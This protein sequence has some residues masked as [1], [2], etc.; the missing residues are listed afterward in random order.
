MFK[1]GGLLVWVCAFL[2]TGPAVA[3][4]AY[5]RF[6]AAIHIHTD[7]S[8]GDESIEQ[9]ATQAVRHGV[10][11]LIVTDDD[12]LRVEYGL[13]FL[14]DLTAVG[15]TVNA[16]FT[17]GTLEEY[18]N[19]I[20]RVNAQYPDVLLIDGIESAPFY[21]WDID[22]TK[23][24]LAFCG[25]NRHTIAVGLDDAVAYAE[26]PVIGGEGNR[27]WHWSSLLLLWPLCGLAYAW[28]WGRAH[29]RW[30]RRGVLVISV[31][32]LVENFPFTV[33][34][35]DAYNG[36]LGPAP[37]Q[38]YIDYVN[39]HNG[40]AFWPHPEAG[41]SIKPL[42]V[43]GGL[44][45]VVS[46][47]PNHGD[48]LVNTYDY[49]GFAALYADAITVTEPGR[50]WDQALGEYVAGQR[51]MPVWGTGEIDYHEDVEGNRIDD[52]LTVFLAR[53]LSRNAVI[54]ALQKGR[55]YAV[56]G[57]D[58]RLVL[59]RFV[60][61]TSQGSAL[62]G[63]TVTSAGEAVVRVRIAHLNQERVPLHV[64]LIKAGEVVAD[65]RGETPFELTHKDAALR[66]GE[67]TYFRLMARGAQSRLTANPIFVDY[68]E[69]E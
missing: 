17:N 38:H 15:K 66:P 58:E 50:Q 54:E 22:W 62:L 28:R 18:L 13:P 24:V 6:D 60:V 8:T 33:P 20:R 26:L 30:L 44:V 10:D 25:W 12:L 35:T 37:Y 63:Q 55:F 23:G 52:I 11:V 57:G 42:E 56:R 69:P 14:R 36:D 65:M 34:L 40:M 67:K 3:E 4:D 7:F 9:V 32:C 61:E 39:A 45:R 43:L 41:S 27:V 46:Q 49:T 68:P 48:D 53:Q 19:E 64:R 2:W 16:L 5:Q 47:T 29:P 31:L 59:E 51:R 1:R 21:Y